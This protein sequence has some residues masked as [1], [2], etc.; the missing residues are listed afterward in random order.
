MKRG[1][2]FLIL[3]GVL[4]G[5]GEKGEKRI[6]C[7][8]G[9]RGERKECEG[10][11][12]RVEKWEMTG[13]EDYLLEIAV[14]EGLCMPLVEDGIWVENNAN[15]GYSC[16]V[17][18]E[19]AWTCAER[20][21]MSYREELGKYELERIVEGECFGEMGFK[22]VVCYTEGGVLNCENIYACMENY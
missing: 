18:K 4:W 8:G 5:C 3:L 21:W 19:K 14:V 1:Y 17:S 7:F 16:L 20:N 13:D 11:W 22:N 9:E 10:C 15:R 12:E 2:I 6:D